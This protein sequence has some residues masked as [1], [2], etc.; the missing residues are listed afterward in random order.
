METRQNIIEAVKRITESTWRGRE[1]TSNEIVEDIKNFLEEEEERIITENEWEEIIDQF[2]IVD[3]SGKIFQVKD[4]FISKYGAGEEEVE[5]E[6]VEVEK[7][8]EKLKE[9]VQKPS[10]HTE[11]QEIDRILSSEK[12]PL[13]QERKLTRTLREI[14]K[15]GIR[16]VVALYKERF[17]NPSVPDDKEL[18]SFI[19]DN[20]LE[21][22][23]NRRTVIIAL[24]RIVGLDTIRNV[25]DIIEGK[26]PFTSKIQLFEKWLKKKKTEPQK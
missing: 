13:E 12:S 15:E 4:T 10:L 6:K 1:H 3:L 20:N 7:E 8:E 14:R 23:E 25:F 21:S 18:T 9:P 26:K 16:K 24:Q 11:T 19:K 17:T 22:K 5:K 2:P